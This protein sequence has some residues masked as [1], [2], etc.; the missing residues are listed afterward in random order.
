M[1]PSPSLLPPVKEGAHSSTPAWQ[2]WTLKVSR[3]HRVLELERPLKSF[4]SFREE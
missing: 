2:V 1:S 3:N 4:I